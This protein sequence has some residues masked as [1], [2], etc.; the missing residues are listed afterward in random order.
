MI[1]AVATR[2]LWQSSRAFVIRLWWR[3]PSLLLPILLKP[4]L[5]VL[6]LLLLRAPLTSTKGL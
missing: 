2:G 3:S 5:D 1:S 6:L 4:L